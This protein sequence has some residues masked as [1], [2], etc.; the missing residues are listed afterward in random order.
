MTP[1]SSATSISKEEVYA[2]YTFLVRREVSHACHRIRYSSIHS[3]ERGDL[4]SEAWIA[5]DNC[6][7]YVDLSQDHVFYIAQAIRRAF[8]AYYRR[9]VKNHIPDEIFQQVEDYLFFLEKGKQRKE[10]EKSPRVRLQ[11]EGVLGHILQY[12]QTQL[13]SRERYI[14]LL[15]ASGKKEGKDIGRTFDPPI[16]KQRVSQIYIRSRNKIREACRQN[17][18]EI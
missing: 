17:G 15:F 3:P 18:I 10:K 5:L 2:K 16:T 6:S 1:A 12:C 8:A 7:K 9:T 13:S 14:F 4:L 11:K